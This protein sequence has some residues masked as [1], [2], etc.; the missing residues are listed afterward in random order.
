MNGG[1]LLG[2]GAGLGWAQTNFE[3]EGELTLQEVLDGP[4]PPAVTSD[5]APSSPSPTEP[6]KAHT[7]G[8][9]RSHGP[10]PPPGGGEAE[11]KRQNSTRHPPLPLPPPP[12]SR[13]GWG[14][15]HPDSGSGAP[16]RPGVPASADASPAP[17]DLRSSVKRICQFLGRPLGEEALESV[18]AH[19]AFNAMK[20]NT[21][22]NFSLLP[23]SLLDQRHGAFLRKGE[24]T[25]GF[26][27]P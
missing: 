2:P 15:R 10:T 25:P 11:A 20:A 4:L 22:S 5:P 26:R 24:G 14:L 7:A 1:A 23:P 21:M 9:P 3:S 18:V 17:Q 12:D 8:N 6:S 27:A 19:S 16:S 13:S